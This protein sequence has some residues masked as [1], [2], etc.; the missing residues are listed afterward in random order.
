[1]APQRATRLLSNGVHSWDI[2]E[3][4]YEVCNSDAEL[5]HMSMLQDLSTSCKRAVQLA[6][7][8]HLPNELLVA[9]FRYGLGPPQRCDSL[10]FELAVSGVCKAW[11]T[12]ALTT[13]DLWTRVFITAKTPIDH[14][15]VYGT[16]SAMHPLDVE[17]CH[18]P[19]PKRRHKYFS[20]EVFLG[21]IL[22]RVRMLVHRFRRFAIWNVS[23][24]AFLTILSGLV[25]VDAPMLRYVSLKGN[26]SVYTT[27]FAGVRLWSSFPFLTRNAPAMSGLEIMHVPIESFSR[28]ELYAAG[29]A[30]LVLKAAED[31][32]IPTSSLP[33]YLITFED[34]ILLL[35]ATTTLTHLALYGPVIDYDDD[36]FIESPDSRVELRS[37]RTLIIHC[38]EPGFRYR[39]TFLSAITA[40]KLARLDIPL[41]DDVEDEF[42][43]DLTGY[44]F[45]NQGF[46][47]FPSVQRL[48]L[49]DSVVK[50]RLPTRSFV[51]AFPQVEDVVLGGNDVW[52]FVA[53]LRGF[54]RYES[55][56]ATGQL[57]PEAWSHVR[58]LTLKDVPL[59]SWKGCVRGLVKWLAAERPYQAG[60]VVVRVEGSIPSD[61]TS[62]F[63]KHL[64]RLRSYSVIEYAVFV[65]ERRKALLIFLDCDH[66]TSGSC[67]RGSPTYD[68]YGATYNVSF[69][70]SWV[71]PLLRSPVLTLKGAKTRC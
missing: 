22:T 27:Y 6:P 56:P 28:A 18:W 58:K 44:L 17:F 20:R 51:R 46:P 38:Q 71:R 13:P 41:H 60:P 55:V 5:V 24:T 31:N 30:S 15:I 23:D 8:S 43:E 34:L 9:I 33:A 42:L 19:T 40:P 61:K 47:K 25:G 2:E 39:S 4:R 66:R 48:Y 49:H 54:V 21:A 63:L 70:V 1:M 65:S 62:W 32:T 52:K 37:L 69:K 26:P 35:R 10:P 29:L 59:H 67:D 11:R 16:R 14:I 50:W 53:T 12:A 36:L 3:Q 68:N 45:D 64:E 57:P 7:V